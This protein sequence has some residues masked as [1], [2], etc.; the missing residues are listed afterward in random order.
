MTDDARPLARGTFSAGHD[1]L[2]LNQGTVKGALL[3]LA[4]VGIVA[5]PSSDDLW[6][7][8][9]GALLVGWALFDLGLR[10]RNTRGIHPA[11]VAQVVVLLAA[12]VALIAPFQ[13]D[14]TLIVG[15]AVVL[16]GVLDLVRAVRAS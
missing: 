5:T 12:G 14:A 11:S 8:A 3:V 7:I 2:W 6:R 16:R 15:V 13:L 4:G 1:P 9:I 10:L